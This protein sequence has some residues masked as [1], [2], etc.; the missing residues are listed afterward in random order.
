MKI[1]SLHVDK[2][3]CV[4]YMIYKHTNIHT[5]IYTHTRMHAY[6]HACIHTCMHTCSHACSQNKDIGGII[7][8]FYYDITKSVYCYYIYS[9][10]EDV[11]AFTCDSRNTILSPPSLPHQNEAVASQ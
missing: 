6:I 1:K 2:V 11:Y 5:H 4:E 10:D 9:E 3:N 8:M 7:F